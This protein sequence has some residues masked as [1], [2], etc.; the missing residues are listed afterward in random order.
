M[1]T[2]VTRPSL[3]PP[4]KPDEETDDDRIYRRVSFASDDYIGWIVGK[5][6][7]GRADLS[8]MRSSGVPVLRSHQSDNLTGQVTRVEKADGVWRSDW[9]LPKIPANRDTFDQMDTGI[10][11]GISVGG[12]LIW[13]TLKIDNEDQADW[14]DPDSI[15]FTCDWML[16]EQSLTSMPA[17]V[18]SG[19]DRETAAVLQRDGAII[20]TIIGPS[21]IMTMETPGVLQRIE[22][23]VR[24]HNA[25]VLTRQREKTMTTPTQVP[26]DLLERSINDHLNRN[27][28]LASLADV[29]GKLDA[30]AASVERLDKEAMEYGKKLNTLQFQPT[31]HVLQA[32]NWQPGAPVINLGRVA[33]LL[34]A[35]DIGPTA[36]QRADWSLEESY[37]EVEQ[38][39]LSTMPRDAIARI[40]WAILQER[41]KMLDLQRA[42]MANARGAIPAMTNILGDGGLLLADYSAILGALDSRLGVTGD[43]KLPY[44]STQPSAAGIVEG[45]ASPH[46]IWCWMTPSTAPPR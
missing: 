4:R 7:L 2:A 46:P 20:D 45:G 8:R 15:L 38:G 6:R 5:L 23:L 12:N 17:D 14:A 19:I 21:G 24:D 44:A 43:Q 39:K 3:H 35:S 40:P 41:S 33:R 18:S 16:F 34:A 9:R 27:E 10:L 29:P 37:L 25:A 11:R 31:G 13:E 36:E 26:L 28:T 32:S 30:L 42:N 1:T 22:T